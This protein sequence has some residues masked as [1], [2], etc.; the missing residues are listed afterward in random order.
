MTVNDT[1]STMRAGIIA[2]AAELL[3][4]PEDP[5]AQ[6]AMLEILQRAL[7]MA[8]QSPSSRGQ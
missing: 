8:P 2:A 6:R 5:A 4:I 3:D 1:G 7:G